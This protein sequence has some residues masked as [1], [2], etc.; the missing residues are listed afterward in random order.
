MTRL[1]AR[2]QAS[3]IKKHDEPLAANCVKEG[4]KEFFCRS[5]G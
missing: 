4:E 5:S 2:G 1:A 3:H